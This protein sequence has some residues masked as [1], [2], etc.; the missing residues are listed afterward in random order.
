MTIAVNN[1]ASGVSG[2]S[3]VAANSPTVGS[4]PFTY[5]NSSHGLQQISMTGGTLSNMTINR[6][7]NSSAIGVTS[8][9][10]LVVPGDSVT[11]T[12][13]AAPTLLVL[14]LT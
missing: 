11:I 1:S 14:Q 12:H 9:T 4:S 13:S 3:N 7:G 8:N 6:N 2:Y 10:V 5:T